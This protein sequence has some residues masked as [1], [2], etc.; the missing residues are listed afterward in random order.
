MILEFIILTK[1]LFMDVIFRRVLILGARVL[2]P[3]MRA[4]RRK[5]IL[6]IVIFIKELCVGRCM[7][8]RVLLL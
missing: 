5:I 7:Q 2:I 8:L 4:M 3:E 6:I 1:F